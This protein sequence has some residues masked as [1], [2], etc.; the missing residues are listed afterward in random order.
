[1]QW[2]ITRDY[3]YEQHK[4]DSGGWTNESNVRGFDTP[5]YRKAAE[6]PL[7]FKIYDDDGVLYYEGRSDE[8]EF[9]PL[10]WAEY[11]A[12]ATSIMYKQQDGSWAWL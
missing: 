8:E 11:V 10:D 5:Q 2:I 1:V 7:Q 9:E 6:L 4:D 3:L 12:G